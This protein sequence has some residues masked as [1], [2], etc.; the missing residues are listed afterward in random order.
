[1]PCESIKMRLQV[2]FGFIVAQK[3][4]CNLR[5]WLKDCLGENKKIH[6]TPLDIED[7]SGDT[8]AKIVCL[9]FIKEIKQNSSKNQYFLDTVLH[10]E[11][12][13]T[14][15]RDPHPMF[16]IQGF[17]KYLGEKAP[18]LLCKGKQV[19]AKKPFFFSTVTTME[20]LF[21]YNIPRGKR[22]TDRRYKRN[23]CQKK[24]QSNGRPH[25]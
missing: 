4:S 5:Q 3:G 9:N 13:L 18:N 25:P 23:Q 11:D 14:L 12:Y 1:M 10:M 20:D 7:F 19:E 2:L 22:R 6:N 24:D 15:D 16:K 8:T 21:K 17:S